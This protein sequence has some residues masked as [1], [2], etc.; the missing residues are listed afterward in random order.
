MPD[1]LSWAFDRV[2]EFS[3]AYDQDSGSENGEILCQP[4]LAESCHAVPSSLGD[5]TRVYQAL[6]IS[7]PK[8][9]PKA[10][11][12]EDPPG[13]ISDRPSSPSSLS[14]PAEDFDDFVNGPISKGVRWTDELL[15]GHE[16][17]YNTLVEPSYTDGKL[18]TPVSSK[19]AISRLATPSFE[20]IPASVLL[21]FSA[22]PK[23]VASPSHIEIDV[24]PLIIQPLK[25]VNSTEQKER[26]VKRLR[27]RY[28][29]PTSLF[30][31]DA[32]AA[33]YS[34]GAADAKGVHVFVDFSNIIIG[35]ANK[36][37]ASRGL[38][39]KAFVRQPPLSY[40]SLALIMER[41]RP[42]ARRC[43]VGSTSKSLYSQ[44]G[45]QKVPK[46]FSEAEIC[47]YEMNILDRVS[48]MKPV[49]PVRRKKN[50]TGNGYATLTSGDESATLTD[51][52][53]PVMAEQ[54]VD[55]ILHMK[56]LESIID[57]SDPTTIVLA[58]GDAA[59]AEYSGGFLK[60]VQRALTKGWK[61]EVL[62]WRDG[63]SREYQSKEFLKKWG[64]HFKVIQLDEYAE[65]M[66]AIYDE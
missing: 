58:S 59:E 63:L 38:H 27:K 11:C 54:G 57:Y 23:K 43:L 10:I 60:T 18:S 44:S 9:E 31:C 40:H 20:L 49:T 62:A 46:H 4:T 24:D 65:D 19:A 37:K 52:K 13:L 14:E 15:H 34:F 26:L 3:K 8:L 5:F 51:L 2:F 61:V 45:P 21:P 50:G 6:G 29:D 33:I 64:D 35:F 39:E 48:K 25:P 32:Q 56:I 42:V 47:G 22:T 1:N 30:E 17:T 16:G 53:K 12:L 41:G 66:L 7:P 28:K 55:E 36:I